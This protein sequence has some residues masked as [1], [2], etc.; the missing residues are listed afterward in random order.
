[1]FLFLI[2]V[3]FSSGRSFIHVMS[4][5]DIEFYDDQ[6]APK[7]LYVGHLHPKVSEE[8]LSELFSKYG[9]ISSCKVFPETPGQDPYAFVEFKKREDADMLEQL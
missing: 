7:S 6:N 9:D 1:M 5:G 4:F 3:Y 2:N 8:L